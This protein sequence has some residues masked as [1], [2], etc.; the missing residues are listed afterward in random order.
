MFKMKNIHSPIIFWLINDRLSKKGDPEDIR[1]KSESLT[2]SALKIP[3]ISTQGYLN[4]PEMTSNWH[5]SAQIDLSQL[6]M[7]SDEKILVLIFLD[8]MHSKTEVGK[9]RSGLDQ[10]KIELAKIQTKTKIWSE[11]MK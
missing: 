5:H 2:Y 6:E 7:T 4:M 1:K 11:S 3:P 8:K 9:K 10:K